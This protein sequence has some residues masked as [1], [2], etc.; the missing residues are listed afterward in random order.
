MKASNI[1]WDI[2]MDEVYERLDEMSADSAAQ[3]LSVPT[4]TYANMT[5]VER[6][7]YAYD[8][9][10]HSSAALDEFFE[11]PD[12]IEIPEELKDDD[13]ISDWL[14]DKFGFCHSWFDIVK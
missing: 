4:K 7:D 2:D 1:K 6:H 8:L 11:L 10:H 12:E 14:S 9:F 5:T 3:A 13:D